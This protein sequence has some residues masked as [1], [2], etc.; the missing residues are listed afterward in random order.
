MKDWQAARTALR[1]VM[2]RQGLTT[3]RIPLD[4]LSVEAPCVACGQMA[5]T[6]FRGQ[7]LDTICA[8]EVGFYAAAVKAGLMPKELAGLFGNQ[9]GSG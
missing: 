4:W 7:P 6:A 5:G 1:A 8:V 9:L 3:E 2:Q